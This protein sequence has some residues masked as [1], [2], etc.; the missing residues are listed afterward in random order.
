M[1]QQNRLFKCIEKILKEK[2]FK[3]LGINSV[4]IE[5]KVSK[6]FI[7]KR[8]GSF[9]NLI[10][11]YFKTKDY[12][13]FKVKKL[14]A[15]L[16]Q[17][18]EFKITDLINFYLKNQYMNVIGNEDLKELI[19]QSVWSK[20]DSLMKKFVSEREEVGE[21]FFDRIKEFQKDPEKIFTFRAL[22][23]IN[24]AALYF[25]SCHFSANNGTFCGLNL[26][27]EKDLNEIFNVIENLNNLYLNQ[28]YQ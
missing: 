22:S 23:A 28:E 20:N 7:Y 6:S 5:S 19:I 3:G 17:N 8:Y 13:S 25:L 24:V 9:N 16:S 2:G 14:D 11:E 27:N 18:N 15:V 4:S 26:N 21:R 12:W 10:E 1:D